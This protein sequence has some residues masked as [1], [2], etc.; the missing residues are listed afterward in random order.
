V[1]ALPTV[2]RPSF[3]LVVAALLTACR[4]DM[5]DQPRYEPLEGNPTYSD[6]R[7]D[8][9]Q[10]EGTVARGQL[11]LDTLLHTGK[12]DGEFAA[13]FPFPITAEVL[14]RGRERY[15]IY[16]SVCH[17]YTGYGMGMAVQRGF[18]Q[19]TSLHDDRLREAPPGYFFDVITNGFGAMYDYADR[20]TPRDRWAIVSYIRALQAS[21]HVPV[22]TLPESVR[23]QLSEAK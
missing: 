22:E 23:Q 11:T 16:C 8:R 9:P 21:Q 17:E 2:F 20:I 13:R 6:G 19:P 4:Q 15:D 18:R 7:A 12:E 10:V 1:S 14:E 5:H 3:I